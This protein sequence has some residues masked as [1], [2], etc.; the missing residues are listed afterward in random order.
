MSRFR[1]LLA[2]SVLLS[3][4]TVRAQQ[5]PP[6][7]AQYT[8]YEYMVPMRDGAKLYASV[9]VP[10]EK[11][12]AHPILLE[13]TPYSA[14]PYGDRAKTGFRGS[15]KMKDAGY[16]FAFAD[17]RGKFMSEGDF[18][19]VRPNNFFRSGPFDVDESTDT[20]DTIDYL[21]K[22]VPQ[23]NGRVGLWGISYPGFYAAIGATCGH[24]ALKAASPQAP[25]S[26]WFMGD[27]FH[28]NGS[29]FV[30]DFFKFMIN[31]GQPRP[32][33][34]PGGSR[35][36]S[37][38]TGGDWYKFFL[39]LGPLSNIDALYYHGNVKFWEDFQSHPD[40]DDWW[41]ARSLPNR[42]TNVKCA[43][44]FVGGWF[45]AEDCYGA[46]NSYQG[47]ERLNPRAYNTI[48]MGPWYHGMWASPQ[49]Q[50][51][52]DMDWGSNT[53]K[54]FQDEI[55][56]PFFDAF[57]RGDGKSGLPEAYVFDAGN[58]AWSKFKEW[59]PK[60]AN[61]TSLY[62]QGGHSLS[63][64]APTDSIG[65]DEYV[66]DPKSPVPSEGGVLRSRTREYM[67]NDQRF[68]S[69]RS[70]VLSY[71]TPALDHDVT[72]AGPVNADLFAELSTTDA[73]FVVKLV[74]VF[75]SDAG[76]KLNDYQML[77]RGEIMPSRYRKSFQNPQ[78][79]PPGTTE[80]VSYTL[81]GLFY[82]FKKGHHIMV[83]VQSSWFP[84]A[85]MSP[86]QFV[87]VYTARAEDYVPC[88]VRLH[89]EAAH[90]SRIRFGSLS[91][92]S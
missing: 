63:F 78:P 16:I 89:R 4:A 37:Y 50:T 58:K 30:W 72:M 61:E 41:Q 53:S 77:V 76:G 39:D 31:F 6:Q 48:V 80:L 69:A 12:G 42:M 44:M 15:Q 59:P 1:C 81:P 33:P 7:Q 86:Q 91:Q 27:D 83:Q 28:H 32:A 9:Y 22:N 84:L 47:T 35:G 2:L 68:A 21:V 14:G 66:S 67:L 82:T 51:F 52:G 49:G 11:P 87:D 13:R 24:P 8:K 43:C 64:S 10:K 3:L 73:D 18:M 5:P 34:G 54:F 74:D 36:P 71:E 90:P 65:A 85:A 56:F 26:D 23:N 60:G 25:V 38:D 57:L 17:V 29:F 55:E 62:F 75:P 46:Q 45:D 79:M 19:D 20:Y 40:F 70:D 92:A 88:T